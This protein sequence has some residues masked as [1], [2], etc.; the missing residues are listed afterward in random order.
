MGTEASFCM[1]NR[2]VM[3]SRWPGGQSRFYK[4]ADGQFS[5][6]NLYTVMSDKAIRAA[7]VF[8]EG[9]QFV[10]RPERIM[11]AF[12]VIPTIMFGTG[13]FSRKT[14]SKVVSRRFGV[15]VGIVDL[16]FPE[17]PID[18]DNERTMERA[19]DV[20]ESRLKEAS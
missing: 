4:F 18:V 16:P 3:E 9:G 15:K 8:R 2:K 6:C 19:R 1:T 13:W 7:E 12:G 17:A 10:K 11:K 5:N 20:L 14:L